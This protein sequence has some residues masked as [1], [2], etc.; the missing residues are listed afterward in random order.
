[1]PK[2]NKSINDSLRKLDEIVGWFEE[3]EE[4][5][6]EKG[7]ARVKE[8]ADLIKE[9]KER[10]KQVENEFAEVKKELGGIREDK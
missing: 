9:L 3:Q 7:L 5:D 4:V 8:G 6:V 2:Q 1:M 10:L